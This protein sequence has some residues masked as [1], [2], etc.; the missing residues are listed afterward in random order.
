MLPARRSPSRHDTR[1]KIVEAASQLLHDHGPTGVTTRGV[2]NAAGVQA[3]TIYRLFGDKDGLLEAVAEHVM[4]TYVATKAISDEVEHASDG[5]PVDALRVSWRTQIDFALANP[6]V[7]A[8]FLDPGR[9]LRSPALRKGTSILEARVHRVALTGRLRTSEERAVD[10]IRAA[11]SGAVRAILATP[12]GQR[13]ASLADD[14]FDAIVRHIVVD[15]PEPPQRDALPVAV[16]FRALAPQLAMLS[17]AER[18][19]LDEWLD[20]ATQHM[21][22][23]AAADVAPGG[24]ALPQA[25]SP[26][27][28]TPSAATDPGLVELV[29]GMTAGGER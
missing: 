8:L 5:D 19:L 14:L 22:G 21:M 15:G 25:T 9:D 23:A 24:E 10:L 6:H 18:Q 26:V 28:A 1:S 13:D 12:P 20:R 4:D 11:G 29:E 27:P 3:P 17:V 2:A 7:F 16:A